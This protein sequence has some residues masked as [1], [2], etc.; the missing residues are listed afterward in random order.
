MSRVIF[1]DRPAKKQLPEV[2]GWSRSS[3]S[4]T[5][6]NVLL[7]KKSA[8]RGRKMKSSL[9]RHLAL[10]V[11]LLLP[12]CGQSD[13][14]QLRG[15]ASELKTVAIPHTD[16]RAQG[17]FG[18]CWAYG[19]IGFVESDYKVRTGADI[20][21]SEESLVFYHMAEGIHSALHTLPIVE[22]LTVL[23]RGQLPEGWYT[24]LS[25]SMRNT[26]PANFKFQL[27][28]LDLIKEYGLVPESAWTFKVG[29][30][31]KKQVL[32]R[33]ISDRIR[34]WGYSGRLS[35]ITMD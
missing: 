18:V 23:S 33:S 17:R 21:L 8:I 35:E 1:V 15:S 31:A 27:D 26:Q 3:L 5:D 32:F 14:E 10:I 16:A 13:R 24:R 12:S 20:D 11:A 29:D 22:V 34:K 19:T 7:H 6:R 9:A 28:A 4:P 25:E 30:A 2:M